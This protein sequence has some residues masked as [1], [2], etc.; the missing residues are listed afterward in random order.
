MMKTRDWLLLTGAVL[1]VFVCGFISGY[2]LKGEP[3][4]ATASV[5][6][7]VDTFLRRDTIREIRP[8]AVSEQETGRREARIAVGDIV[9]VGDTSFARVAQQSGRERYAGGTED[10]VRGRCAGDVEDSVGVWLTV[11]QRV[12]EGEDYRAYVSGVDPRLDSIM[13]YARRETIR[14]HVSVREK[15]RRWHIGPA[16]GFGYGREGFSPFVGVCVSYSILSF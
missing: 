3:E 10:S 13:I 9:A 5:S 15:A 12:Y 14:E 11:S 2:F 8:V 1:L 6:V 4:K 7:R 16:V